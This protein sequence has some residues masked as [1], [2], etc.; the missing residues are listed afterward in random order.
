MTDSS[1]HLISH[2]APTV[3]SNIDSTLSPA[4][5]SHPFYTTAQPDELEEDD[6]TIKCI[7]G[8]KHDDGNSVFCERCNTW[9]H[10]WCYYY[11]EENDR[12]PPK[13]ELEAI[14]HFCTDCEPRSINVH[15]A[16]NRQKTRMPDLDFDERK[17][18]KPASRSHKKKAKAIE[19]NGVSMNGWLTDGDGS[20]ERTIRSPRDHGPSAKKLKT[21]HRPANSV[22]M[23]VLSQQPT[24][25]PHKRSGSALQSPSKHPVRLSS[26]G[27][28]KEHYSDD[29]LQLYDDDPG[30][31]NMP[32]NIFNNISITDTLSS[33]TYNPQKLKDDTRGFS[34]ADVFHRIEQHLE[35]IMGQPPRKQYR[36]EIS[37]TK[38][39][40]HPRWI[41]LTSDGLTKQNSIVGELKG[42]I[43]HMKDYISDP[44]NRWDWLRH[45]APFVF[46]HPKLPI[47]IDTRREGTLCRYL[48]RS[49]R[50][51]LSMTTFLENDSYHFC[52]TAKEDIDHGQEMTIGW[53]PD[54]HMRKF[55]ANKN[56]MA[57]DLSPDGEKYFTD[58]VGRVSPEFGGCACGMPD[59]C[60]FVRYD[61]ENKVALRGKGTHNKRRSQSNAQDSSEDEEVAS[62]SR[63]NSG[64][65]DMTPTGQSAHT[66]GLGL[67]NSD[68]EKRKIA[69]LE[70]NF[71]LLEND[72]HQPATRKKKR[73]SGGSNT[74]TPSSGT[75]VGPILDCIRQD[76]TD[77]QKQRQLGHNASSLSQPNTPSLPSRPQYIDA[78][79][80]GKNISPSA[81]SSA[82]LGHPRNIHPT[83]FRKK[84]S[85][86]N[87]PSI[88]SPL[89]CP[90]YVSSATQT[91]R[92]DEED[93]WYKPS[94][95]STR[96][97]KPYMSLT[98]RLLL[99][100]QYDRQKL[101]ERRHTASA[102]TGQQLPGVK[103]STTVARM[104]LSQPQKDIDK[105]DA[106]PLQDGGD[107]AQALDGIDKPSTIIPSGDAKPPLWPSFDKPALV[108]G[109][110]AT[111]LYVRLPSEPLHPPDSSSN[112]T[113]SQT[114]TSTNLPQSPC[115]Q[116]PTLSYPPP[117]VTSSS[118]GLVQPS[119][120]KKKVSLSDYFRRK[121]S[122]STD[123]KQLSGSPELSHSSLR[124]PPTLSAANG[125]S[126]LEGSAV[127][128]TPG[129]EE[130]NPLESVQGLKAISPIPEENPSTL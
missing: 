1:S 62:T 122:H 105:Q 102:S 15:A 39:G 85:R 23:P 5:P 61:P 35:N 71:E 109:F 93:D 48:R 51:N 29:F 2:I 111:D 87:T 45:P 117:F 123:T 76:H 32:T 60:W 106:G 66:S 6:Y 30:E 46:F 127:V 43:G 26:T 31:Q 16:I 104:H 68:R 13:D 90:N 84:P 63:S 67:E 24:S 56:D 97:R 4:K 120:A 115:I 33:W 119:P 57:Q 130:S 112:T 28:I 96:P 55:S 98:K 21:N 110:R 70:K 124:P 41:Y 114:P 8:F 19:S 86:P 80:T 58:W 107:S 78:S 89:S 95:F 83:P 11:D 82:S 52:F 72:R 108:N 17:A 64:S 69:A 129:K 54:E 14:L 88:P 25:H 128:D 37:V 118:T 42:S 40:R 36:E 116:T 113:L 44:S 121:G 12:V 3:Q 34:R 47:F 59:S 103:S 99:R 50:P 77:K 73:H 81:K 27:F 49:C 20:Y 9:Q 79:T 125:A 100:S 74:N 38:N 101:E 53:V 22:N 126:T 75:S 94:A 92:D 18:K 91:D 7:C 10:T 65:R